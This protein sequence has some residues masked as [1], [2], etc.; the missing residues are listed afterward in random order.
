MAVQ[1]K[2]YGDVSL[3]TAEEAITELYETYPNGI[4][5]LQVI[6]SGTSVGTVTVIACYDDGA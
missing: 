2:I 5:C 4:K 3:T 1:A 6:S